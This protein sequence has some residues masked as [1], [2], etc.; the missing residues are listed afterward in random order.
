MNTTTY[1]TPL[2][3]AYHDKRT[4]NNI[5]QA[6]ETIADKKSIMFWSS[7]ENRAD[8]E[9]IRRIIGVAG[10]KTILDD[11]KISAALLANSIQSL[12]G[13]NNIIVVHDPSDIRKQYSNQLEH[14]GKVLSLDKKIING[15][16]S[17]CSIAVDMASKELKLLDIELYSNRSP[18]YVT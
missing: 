3:T 2:L 4:R 6:F 17:F 15:Y 10:V 9:R 12:A 7:T 1:L 18:N 14:L 5:Q 16:N 11:E 8:Y 13:K